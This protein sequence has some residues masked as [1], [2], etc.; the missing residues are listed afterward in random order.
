[1]TVYKCYKHAEH[2][3]T[4]NV[5]Y[6]IITP[7]LVIE[8]WPVHEQL[9]S[10]AWGAIWCACMSMILKVMRACIT[11]LF[12]LSF[13]ALLLAMGQLSELQAITAIR[14]L[15]PHAHSQG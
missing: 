6:V 12:N 10:P 3:T 1:M 13:Q 7:S 15:L 9:N 5:A 8:Y 4:M 2:E 14:W 11:S